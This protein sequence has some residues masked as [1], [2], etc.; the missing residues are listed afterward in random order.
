MD[1]KMLLA[2]QRQADETHYQVCLEPRL[3]LLRH[4][5]RCA[6][7]QHQS[8]PEIV[9]KVLRDRHGFRG[10]DFLF[11]LVREYPRRELVVQW[12]ESDLDFIQRILAESRTRATLHLPDKTGVKLSYP[13]KDGAGLHK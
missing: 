13:R 10:Q 7:Y 12:Q 4:T 2:R 5:R 11:T 8:V 1:R 6:I 9:E 3:A